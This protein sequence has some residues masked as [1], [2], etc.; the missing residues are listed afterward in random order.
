MLAIAASNLKNRGITNCSLASTI[1]GGFDFLHS[2]LVFQHIPLKRGYEIFAALLSR[3]SPG[4]VGAVH[5][6]YHRD[7]PSWKRF[8]TS[9]LNHA[10]PLL[11]K[12][13]PRMQNNHYSLTKL[14]AILYEHR[15]QKVLVGQLPPENGS[16]SAMLYFVKGESSIRPNCA[17]RLV[18]KT[19]YS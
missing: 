19:G 10:E 18:S 9:I 7:A 4:G 12:R 13:E 17:Q 14:L 6:P 11:K 2:Y 3:L 8:A 5:F 16:M 1:S 15:C